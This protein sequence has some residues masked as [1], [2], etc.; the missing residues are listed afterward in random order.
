MPRPWLAARGWPAP[1]PARRRPPPPQDRPDTRPDDADPTDGD[2]TIADRP[3]FAGADFGIDSLEPEGSPSE[4][5]ADYL[6]I[7]AGELLP[8]SDQHTTNPHTTDLTSSYYVM[9]DTAHTWND[10]PGLSSFLAVHVERDLAAGV[11]EIGFAPQPLAAMAQ[12]W[13]V[14]RGA[15]P[16]AFTRLG[17]ITPADQETE[18]VESLL[19]GAG[20]DRFTVHDHYTHDDAPF[21]IWVIATDTQAAASDRPVRVFHDRRQADHDTYTLREG[22]FADF[23]AAYAWTE[24]TDQPLPPVPAE[25]T[26]RAGAARTQ[27]PHRPSVPGRPAT[28][29]YSGPTPPGPSPRR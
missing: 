14:E 2:P 16:A 25:G 17:P 24:D 4:H 22:A 28:Q 19:R 5:A 27:S 3:I 21:D 1:S 6:A 13:L 18:R 11:F 15:D 12:Q 20:P 29:P 23:E 26:L 7:I 8:L 10:T 9:A